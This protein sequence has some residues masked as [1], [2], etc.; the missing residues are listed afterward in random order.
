MAKDD[1]SPEQAPG[2]SSEQATQPAPPDK[3]PPHR[4]LSRSQIRAFKEIQE[5]F[6]HDHSVVIEGGIGVGEAAKWLQTV[7]PGLKTLEIHAD[8]WTNFE[9]GF[10]ALAR[11]A[12][13]SFGSAPPFLRHDP[14]QESGRRMRLATRRE[15][16]EQFEKWFED[17]SQMCTRGNWSFGSGSPRLIMFFSHH[18][19]IPLC[20]VA[21][22]FGASPS[23]L[24]TDKDKELIILRN[25][26]LITT[27]YTYCDV[28]LG[29][30]VFQR[31]LEILPGIKAFVLRYLEASGRLGRHRDLFLARL[32][33]AFDSHSKDL[34]A[35][36]PG[37]RHLR[38]VP[39]GQNAF[40]L[41][42]EGVDARDDWESIIYNT[43]RCIQEN[44]LPVG[45]M[46]PMM[47]EVAYIRN[48][49]LVL[50]RLLRENGKNQW[51][52]KVSE[53]IVLAKERNP[54]HSPSQKETSSDKN[55]TSPLATGNSRILSSSMSDAACLVEE[56]IEL[57]AALVSTFLR[58][59]KWW[60]AQKISLGV[61][62]AMRET[63]GEE[64]PDTLSIRMEHAMTSVRQ[65]QWEEADAL[66]RRL[67]RDKERVFDE[68]HHGALATM[69]QLGRLLNNGAWWDEAEY[70][71]ID[72][73]KRSSTS[74][75]RDDPDVIWSMARL[76]SVYALGDQARWTEF[77]VAVKQIM[78][79]EAWKK[80]KIHPETLEALI[81][82]AFKIRKYGRRE[83]SVVMLSECIKVLEG[84][85]D[86]GDPTLRK[87]RS[88]LLLWEKG[89]PEGFAKQEDVGIL[90]RPATTGVPSLW[91]RWVTYFSPPAAGYERLYFRC[92]RGT[93][94]NG[95]K[96]A[97][98]F[99]A[100]ESY[101]RWIYARLCQGALTVCARDSRGVQLT[102]D[103]GQ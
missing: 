26:H 61:V 81:R 84:A 101:F 42:P 8:A 93:K 3:A 31:G 23:T 94:A 97:N 90:G 87:S 10:Q 2:A 67:V 12:K 50:A 79:A 91:Q 52:S 53:Q 14:Y 102:S 41:F 69:T 100:A 92:V 7:H 99:R 74:L 63:L 58:Y 76:A 9:G 28:E 34:D 73:I 29:C 27:S 38:L 44:R 49:S 54:G 71:L 4:R 17:E 37:F 21:A 56:L 88:S 95:L 89:D 51:Q 5:R 19:D 98:V 59:R 57:Q 30:E 20:L 72:V 36:T 45:N 75:R 68:S 48:S 22:R 86:N 13:A 11:K 96:E 64:H 66:L 40:S 70:I 80:G 78:D 25:L 39:H 16:L 65:E 55:T 1:S 15:N 43:G 82:L 47:E 77:E 83:H 32:A 6:T 35:V 60:K 18:K 24:E 46:F 103:R 62:E 33:K 85:F